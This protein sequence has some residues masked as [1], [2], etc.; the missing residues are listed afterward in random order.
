MRKYLALG[1]AF[2]AGLTAAV[3]LL[4]AVFIAQ[5]DKGRFNQDVG[6]AQTLEDCRE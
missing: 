1:I 2:L 3:A 6:I 4:A 5:P